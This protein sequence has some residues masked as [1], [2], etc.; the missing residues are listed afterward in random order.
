MTWNVKHFVDIYDNPY[1]G[2]R[3]ED[4]PDT[5]ALAEKAQ[6]FAAALGKA[7]A[8]IVVLQEI[9]NIQLA[10]QLSEDLFP[11]LEY[12]FFADAESINWYQNVV[13]MSRFP[14]GVFESYGTVHSP[15]AYTDEEGT[16]KYETQSMINTRMWKVEVMIDAD[17][18]FHLVGVHL[19]A[20]RGPRNV[21]MRLGQIGLI[22]EQLADLYSQNKKAN[23]I[24][25]GDLNS[26][27]GSEEMKSI[28]EGVSGIEF[29]DP[30]PEN[31]FTHATDDLQRRLDYIIINE[32]M[33][34]ELVNGSTRVPMLLDREKMEKVSDH[35]PVVADFVAKEN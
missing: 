31:V 15:V 9:E 25:T 3:R 27:P 21:A 26:Y 10:K 17:Y 16:A 35:L 24:F 1:I 11:E 2:N 14:L 4:N 30:L 8:D 20:G 29:I 12:A 22:K 23:V 6:L 28:L 32:N 33:L 34:P 19:K 5:A 13:V 18:G 7:N